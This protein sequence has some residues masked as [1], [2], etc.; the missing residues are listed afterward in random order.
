M[1]LG[2]SGCSGIPEVPDRDTS[3]HWLTSARPRDATSSVSSSRSAG[4]TDSRCSPLGPLP[5]ACL[6]QVPRR[7]AP[8]PDAR[9]GRA[10]LG[11]TLRARPAK[12]TASGVLEALASVALGAAD[13]CRLTGGDELDVVA[14]KDGVR[15][16]Q[17]D[18]LDL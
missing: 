1:A 7:R 18:T 14:V 5:A 4:T 3:E 15:R 6:G 11:P 10:R 8:P 9:A 17:G 13:R 2:P 16:H 12:W